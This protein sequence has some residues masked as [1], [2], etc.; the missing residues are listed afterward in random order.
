MAQDAICSR[1]QVHVDAAVIRM[2]DAG[3][4][5][6]LCESVLFEWMQDSSNEQFKAVS[7][8]IR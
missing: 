4:H 3:I 6:S 1:Q 5:A 8:L 2:R 7:A